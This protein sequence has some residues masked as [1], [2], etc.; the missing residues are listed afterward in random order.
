MQ[1]QQSNLES[2]LELMDNEEVIIWEAPVIVKPE[3][4]L[5]YDEKGCVISYS[6]GKHDGNYVIID[7]Q[8]YAESRPDVRVVDGKLVKINT[9]SVISRLVPDNEGTLCEREDLSILTDV[10]GQY[11]NLKTYAF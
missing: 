10:D 6:C 3:F 8:T 11:W 5:Y 1:N 7:A 4:R 9:H 2:I